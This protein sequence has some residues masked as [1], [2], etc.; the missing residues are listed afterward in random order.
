M[1]QPRPCD[2]L[3][4]PDSHS[5]GLQTLPYGSFS[6]ARHPAARRVGVAVGDRVLDLTAASER[7]LPG[8]A[9]DFATGS[10]DRFLAAGDGAWA[11]VRAALTEWLSEDHYRSAI[12]DLLV[13]TD[14]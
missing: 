10:L 7:L 5:F 8:R 12:E 13:E 11:Q 3:A 14:R 4:I 2:W 6:N 9:A 1:A